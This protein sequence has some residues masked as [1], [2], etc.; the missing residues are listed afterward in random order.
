MNYGRV[1]DLLRHPVSSAPI[2]DLLGP[3]VIGWGSHYFCK[4]PGDGKTVS[5]HRDASC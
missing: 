3:D 2:C 5:W 1:Y 4:M